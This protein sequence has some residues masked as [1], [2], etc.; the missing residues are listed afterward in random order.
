MIGNIK[1]VQFT[2]HSIGNSL[3]L[4]QKKYCKRTAIINVG[5]LINKIIIM[6][7]MFFALLLLL[8]TQPINVP[9]MND[10][11]REIEPNIAEIGKYFAIISFELMPSYTKEFPKSKEKVLLSMSK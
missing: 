6:K 9:T 1:L 8:D 10:V 4:T 11:K 2:D 5:K 7:K 3:N